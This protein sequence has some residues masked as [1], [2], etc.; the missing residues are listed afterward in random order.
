VSK[1][2]K[3]GRTLVEP[4]APSRIR[5]DPVRDEKE[6]FWRSREWEIRLSVAG[7]VLFALALCT[8]WVGINQVTFR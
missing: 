5:R 1:Q 2:F 8:I 3:P 4:R 6:A 7:I